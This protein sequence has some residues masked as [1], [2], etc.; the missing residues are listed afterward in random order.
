MP[1]MTTANSEA[2]IRSE[3]WSTQLKTVLEDDLMA[4]SY[5]KWMSEFPDG[6]QFTIPSIGTLTAN[7]Y[8]E[9]Q[10]IEY[11]ALDTGEFNFT[12]NQYLSSA[13]YITKKNKQDGFYMSELVSG[14]VPKQARAIRERLEQDILKEGQPKTG[15][16]AGYQVAG[17]ANSINGASHRRVGS[18]V[19]NTKQV[20][21]PADFSYALYALKKANV[22]QENL[23]AIVDPSVEVVIN[24]LTNLVNASN[25]P[26][27]EGIIESG[28]GSGMKFIKNIYGFDVYTSN[29]LPLCG[30]NQSGASET[31]GGTASGAN[32]VSNLFFS[33]SA[34]VLPYIGAWRQMP[35]VDGEYNKDRQ[36]DEYVTTA[37]YG[38]KIYRPENLVT[39]LSDPSAVV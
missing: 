20:I 30:Q 13:T 6:N 36:R 5:V 25:N 19:F 21:G 15:N 27:W 17:N 14:F 32:A 8:T 18:T 39:I 1:G 34:D 35:E 38:V 28:I 9:D 3:L 2:L 10:P 33:A 31:I 16:P 23:I 29:R 7:D 26:R 24:N 37:R 11:S 12:I 4:N 22:P